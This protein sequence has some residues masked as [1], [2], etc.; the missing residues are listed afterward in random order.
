[1]KISFYYPRS[2]ARC[3]LAD[4]GVLTVQWNR[5]LVWPTGTQ[6]QS[7]SFAAP[8][9]EDVTVSGGTLKAITF[10]ATGLP[11]GL[12]MEPSGAVIGVPGGPE[13][14]ANVTVFARHGSRTA[15]VQAI[16]AAS[17]AQFEISVRDCDEATTCENGGTC[18][19]VVPFDGEYVCQC[20]RGWAGERC[21]V[22]LQSSSEAAGET[23]TWIIG[24]A[25]G[26]GGLLLLVLMLVFVMRYRSSQKKNR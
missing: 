22:R 16:G 26:L 2:G 15:T 7:Y 17:G 3:E 21:T 23:P 11:C 4:A 24:L 18:D 13:R 6:G 10:Q 20:A 1:M 8:Q 25:A 9:A 12:D 5:P 19:D 14:L